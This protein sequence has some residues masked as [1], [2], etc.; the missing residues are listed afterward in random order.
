MF[1]PEPCPEVIEF[2]ESVPH[3]TTPATVVVE[4]VAGA[5]VAAA[6][7]AVAVGVAVALELGVELEAGT[8]VGGVCAR[9]A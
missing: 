5:V 6:L 2:E 9:T 8:A 3:L 1:G 7:V 4:L